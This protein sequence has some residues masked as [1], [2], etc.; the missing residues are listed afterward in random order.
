LLFGAQRDCPTLS[1]IRDDKRRFQGD[2]VLSTMARPF[3]AAPSIPA[4]HKT[5]NAMN[6]T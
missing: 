2:F 4:T 6:T 5:T 1:G 3:R